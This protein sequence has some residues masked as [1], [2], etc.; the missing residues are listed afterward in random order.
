M[1][2]LQLV[3]Q[4][5]IDDEGLWASIYSKLINVDIDTVK[6][7]GKKTLRAAYEKYLQSFEKSTV[8]HEFITAA[9]ERAKMIEA[10]TKD[11]PVMG[12]AL[13]NDSGSGSAGGGGGR[14]GAVSAVKKIKASHGGEDM[15][16][17][18]NARPP[19]AN[20]IRGRHS[21]GDASSVHSDASEEAAVA[22]ASSKDVMAAHA[23]TPPK[24]SADTHEGTHAEQE[25]GGLSL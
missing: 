9:H 11:L 23:A 14:G 18:A 24:Q 12:G 10:A 4:A 6:E 2:P 25:C 16:V 21:V 19:H 17:E 22:V 7:S 5:K 3:G 8:A 20:L 15:A 13:S 1:K